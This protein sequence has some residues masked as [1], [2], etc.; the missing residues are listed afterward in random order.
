M[1]PRKLLIL[2]LACYLNQIPLFAAQPT[3]SQQQI[4]IQLQKGIPS[5]NVKIYR[6][7]AYKDRTSKLFVVSFKT[8]RPIQA[9]VSIYRSKK[10]SKNPVLL[11]YSSEKEDKLSPDTDHSLVLRE[12]GPESLAT[13]KAYYMKIIEVGRAS[14]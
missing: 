4:Q 7:S 6:L 9:Q 13:E 1:I 14:P 8:D 5:G 3:P 2:S 10:G 12:S 11:A